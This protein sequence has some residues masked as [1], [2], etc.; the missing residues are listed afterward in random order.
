MENN[1]NWI[2]LQIHEPNTIVKKGIVQ[3]KG[4]NGR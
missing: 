2:R 4:E 3:A 1:S